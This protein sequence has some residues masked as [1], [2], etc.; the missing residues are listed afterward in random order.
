MF[1]P[2]LFLLPRFLT[3]DI[4]LPRDNVATMSGPNHHYRTPNGEP[5]NGGV[6]LIP[7]GYQFQAM[8]AQPP[9]YVVAPPASSSPPPA[10]GVPHYF[11]HP[12]TEMFL[13]PQP[14]FPHPPEAAASV[15]SQ[16]ET[17]FPCPGRAK[18]GQQSPEFNEANRTHFMITFQ[19]HLDLSRPVRAHEIGIEIWSVPSALPVG[20][21]IEDMGAPQG[22]HS[23]FG[24]TELC[25][26]G[27]GWFAE[28]RSIFLN[29]EP[30]RTSLKDLGWGSD[31]GTTAK[32]VFIKI[33]RKG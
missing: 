16:P 13:P 32:P 8:V 12:T 5:P 33:C 7:P 21:L 15:P 19:L 14:A 22:S 25:E 11:P 20:Q 29:T 24:I 4:P 10:Y 23:R 27:D 28:G 17:P 6:P 3:L 26:L 2:D 30:A 31:R 9:Q 18:Y 1:S